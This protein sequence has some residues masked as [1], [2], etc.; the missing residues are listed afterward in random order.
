MSTSTRRPRRYRVDWVQ[1][2]AAVVMLLSYLAVIVLCF[3]PVPPSPLATPV[4]LVCLGSSTVWLARREEH[5]G[6]E[7][8]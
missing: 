2:A 8:R 3:A 6:G 4:M 7:Q 1:L 5:D